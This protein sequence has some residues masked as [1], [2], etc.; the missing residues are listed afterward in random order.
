MKVFFILLL[1]IFANASYMATITQVN[2]LKV[3]LNIPIKKG[4]SGIVLCPYEGEKII[5]ARAISFGKYAKLYPYRNLKNDAFA[6]PLVYP[7]KGDK[8]IFGK[9]YERVLIIAPN[10]TLYLTFKNRYKNLTIIP[11]DTFAAFLDDWPTKEDFIDFANKMDI[12]LFVF[13]LDK[14]YIVDAHSFVVLLKEELPFSFKNFKEPFYSS[15]NFSVKE[16]NMISYYK[17]L[18]KGIDD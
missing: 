11:I 5:C 16:K 17:N 4:S 10:Q 18:L 12:G 6:L 7:K 8:V 13:I 3:K 1:A 14:I 15:Y 9:N 2:G